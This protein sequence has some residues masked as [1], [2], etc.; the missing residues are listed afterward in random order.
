MIDGV[1]QHQDSNGG[2]GLIT[3]GATQ[4][5]TAGAGILH[6]ETPPEELVVTGGLFHGIQLWVNLPAEEKWSPPR[7][8]DI[9][10]R[11]V[12]L[13]SLGRRRRAGAR[14][15]RRPRRPR[16]PGLDAHA[17]HRTST[18][19]SRPG[20]GSRLPWRP[21]FNALVYV[22]AGRGTVGAERRPVQRGQL[23]VFG[24]GDAPRASPPTPAQDSRTPSSEVLLL[25][26]RPIREPVAHTGRS[27]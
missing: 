8:Q 6:I 25:G 4:W 27:S 20:R 7:Y 22:L 9:E 14:H 15:R 13:L 23:A 12:A 3:D 26:G 24:A 1:F 5:M 21:D 17:D 2:G 16:R 19:R 18:P 11:Q 10:R